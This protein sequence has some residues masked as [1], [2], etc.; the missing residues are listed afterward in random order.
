MTGNEH[1]SQEDLVLHALQALSQG[2]SAAVRTHLAQCAMCRDQVAELSGD[3][4]M[5][6]LS[7]PQHPVPAGARQRFLNRIAADVL[8]AKQPAKHE[9]RRQVLP[10][11]RTTWIPWATAA[12]L[13]VVA[14]SLGVKNNALNNEL[15]HA[16]SQVTS[17]EAES[18]QARRV[19]DVLTSHSAQRVLLTAGKTSVEPAGHAI[20]LAESGS[21]IFQANN[22]KLLASDRSYEL[23][24]IP[25]NGK[26]IPAG[27]F[28]PDAAG[29]ASVVLP[30]LPK[31]VPAKA[32][33]VTI[34]KA[35]GSD[36]PTA[37]I[38]ISGATASTAG[39]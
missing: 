39:E 12:A 7:V 4:A 11:P 29:D 8:V 14:I 13:A 15:H 20:Y 21:L 33:G 38:I 2:E 3:V 5:L 36:T 27:L 16:T 25:A 19:I 35:E 37:P 31:G 24:V 18:A 26:P 6:G 22:L 9:T 17:L 10:F 1:I 28:R 32:F 34:E 23:W 30:S